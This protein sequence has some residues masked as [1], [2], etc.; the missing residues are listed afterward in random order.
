MFKNQYLALVNL[1]FLLLWLCNWLFSHL[2][3][4]PS[5]FVYVQFTSK[6]LIPQASSYH[7]ISIWKLCF[8][9]QWSQGGGGKGELLLAKKKTKS[10]IISFVS[11]TQYVF[12]DQISIQLPCVPSSVLACLNLP[13]LQI[14]KIVSFRLHINTCK[15]TKIEY[16]SKSLK[17][18]LCITVKVELPLG[19]D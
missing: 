10:L 17:I 19:L 7:F 14:G 1:H 13:F 5:Y 12:K 16:S 11:T 15:I 6:T 9:K 3:H 18:I 8:K 4:I 2:I